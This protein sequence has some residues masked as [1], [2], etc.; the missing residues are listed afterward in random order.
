MGSA[1]NIHSSFHRSSHDG[2]VFQK[3]IDKMQS[4]GYA[5]DSLAYQ[6]HRFIDE[7][8]QAMWSGFYMAKQDE[9]LVEKGHVVVALKTESGFPYFSNRPRIHNRLHK[10]IA[11]AQRLRDVGIGEDFFL[12]QMVGTLREIEADSPRVREALKRLK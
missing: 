9:P 5:E 11:E 3:F 4:R 12:Y 6:N 7:T 8:I 2:V 10:A 1:F